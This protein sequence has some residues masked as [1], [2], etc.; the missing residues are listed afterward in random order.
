MQ[1]KQKMQSQL[2]AV[3]E[4]NALVTTKLDFYQAELATASA[5]AS[6]LQQEAERLR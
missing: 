2:T 3:Q 6:I 4:A 1:D 5:K